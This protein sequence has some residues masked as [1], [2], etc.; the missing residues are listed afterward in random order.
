LISLVSLGLSAGALPG[1]PTRLAA[2][3]RMGSS[4]AAVGKTGNIGKTGKIGR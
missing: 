2:H 3:G 1:D 4:T